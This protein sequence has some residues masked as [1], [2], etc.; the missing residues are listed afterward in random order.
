MDI[1]D[2]F[3]PVE[4]LFGF[5][6]FG[7]VIMLNVFITKNVVLKPKSPRRARTLMI[8]LYPLKFGIYLGVLIFIDKI[9]GLTFSFLLG[10]VGSLTAF[11]I[12]TI[13]LFTLGRKGK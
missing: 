2:N 8:A 11:L 7:S 13:I 6:I 9:M 4:F 1:L 3:R 5:I 12:G 10:V